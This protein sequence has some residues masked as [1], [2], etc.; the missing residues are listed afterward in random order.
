MA[1]ND[2]EYHAVNKEVK[3]FVDSIRPPEHVRKELDMVYNIE[4]QTIEIG[5]LRPVW[6]GEPGETHFLPSVR[7]KYIRSLKRW[8][9][10]WMRQDLKW[11][12]Y[13]TTET[14][15]EALEVVRVDPDSC[16]FG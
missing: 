3:A 1:F 6:R 2:L 16:F 7:I 14:L 9:L 8:K 11:H 10:Y 15:T 13:D 5:A 4:D 12:L